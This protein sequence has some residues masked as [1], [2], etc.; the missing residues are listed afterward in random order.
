VTA[1]VLSDRLSGIERVKGF[2]IR[3]VTVDGGE[4]F[5]AADVVLA[6]MPNEALVEHLAAYEPPV[7]W[8]G[9]KLI[10]RELLAEVGA[11]NDKAA[12]LADELERRVQLVAVHTRHLRAV[13]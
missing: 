9:E 1:R 10:P 8:R 13:A 2:D 3:R 4:W 12:D 7:Q 5:V 6:T 11:T